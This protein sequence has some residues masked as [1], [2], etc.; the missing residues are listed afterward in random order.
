MNEETE[1]TLAR[2]IA[3][4]DIRVGDYLAILNVV[5]EEVPVM[6][7]SEGWSAAPTSIEPVRMLLLPCSESVPLKVQA[8]CLPFVLVK[9][10]PRPVFGPSGGTTNAP[11]LL[12]TLD[13]R[14][15]RLARLSA[16]Y[17]KRVY[18]MLKQ[19]A[20]RKAESASDDEDEV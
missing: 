7:P 16:D 17:G 9:S 15:Y 4:E 18:K 5:H 12:R 20:G 6:V 3:P 19:R 11:A 13:T 1:N 8:V 14:R 2:A 10:P